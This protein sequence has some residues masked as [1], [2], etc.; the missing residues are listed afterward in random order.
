[1]LSCIVLCRGRRNH[2][3]LCRT[4]PCCTSCNRA[5]VFHAVPCRLS[6]CPAMPWCDRRKRAKPL[7]SH[8]RSACACRS[9]LCPSHPRF[10]VEQ[11]DHASAT[12]LPRSKL[13]EQKSTLPNTDATSTFFKLF[14]SSCDHNVLLYRSFIDMQD[15][16]WG[17]GPFLGTDGDAK[18]KMKVQNCV[19]MLKHLGH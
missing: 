3:A 8:V 14:F 13:F 4:M 11:P 9:A 5:E 7:Q 2:D 15:A 16:S 1:M 12:S 6:T 10:T 18:M 19:S 17:K